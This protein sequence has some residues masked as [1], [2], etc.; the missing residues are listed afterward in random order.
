ML[1]NSGGYRSIANHVRFEKEAL[2]DF[3]FLN[4]VFHLVKCAVQ[5]QY[6]G[7]VKRECSFK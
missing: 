1:I 4:I 3:F 6:R 7:K 2:P 5:S